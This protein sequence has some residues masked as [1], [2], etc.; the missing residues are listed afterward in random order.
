MLTVVGPGGQ[1]TLIEQNAITITEP[2]SESFTIFSTG[3]TNI[4]TSP[5]GGFCLM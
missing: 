4:D 5:Q 3:N 1:S 2:D